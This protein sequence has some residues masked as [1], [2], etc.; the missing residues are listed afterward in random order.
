MKR[1]IVLLIASGLVAG[2]KKA[3]TDEDEIRAIL[4]TDGLFNLAL[5]YG[6]NPE[7]LV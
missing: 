7:K 1:F 4:E 6:G 3:T 5:V 2:C